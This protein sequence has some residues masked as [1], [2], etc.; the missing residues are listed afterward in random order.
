MSPCV[1]DFALEKQFQDAYTNAKFKEVQA[2]FKQRSNVNNCLLKSEGAIFTYQV[3]ETN[4]NCMMNKTFSVFFNTDEF[5]VKCTCALFEVK[6]IIC[7]HSI[8]ILLT[9]G[10]TTLPP[11]YILY[12]WRKD[13]NRKHVLIKS[14]GDVLVNNSNAQRYDE[15]CKHCE[16]LALLTSKNVKYFIEVMKSVDML[17]EKYRALTLAEPNQCDEVIPT[18]DEVILSN[19]GTTVQG[20]INVAATMVDPMSELS[21]LISQHK[22]EEAFVAAF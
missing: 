20:S 10:V 6:G 12:R 2:E 21:K 4:G 7:R 1:A 15:F 13:I 5:E 8:S 19:E 14:S 22:Y 3:I 18:C 9:S 16:E 11:K 17:T